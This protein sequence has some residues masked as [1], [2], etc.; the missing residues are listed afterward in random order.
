MHPYEAYNSVIFFTE[1]I[2][3]YSLYHTPILE[4]S[5]IP[6]FSPCRFT[7]CS[8]PFLQLQETRN[9]LCVSVDLPFL[10]ISYKRN[11]IMCSTLCP[12]SFR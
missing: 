1:F 12:A 8:D 11:P 6:E 9:L 10:G 5:V 3:L 2:D 7:D 4:C